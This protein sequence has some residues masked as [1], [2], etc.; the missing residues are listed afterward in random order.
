MSKGFCL[1][2]SRIIAVRASVNY[3]VDLTDE[4]FHVGDTTVHY[5][6]V[7]NIESCTTTYTGFRRKLPSGEFGPDGFWDVLP[8][9]DDAM[10][11]EGEVFGGNPFPY[12]PY[13]WSETYP[14]VKPNY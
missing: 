7:C 10:G 2:C 8:W 14:N 5:R 11:P 3:R 13:E 6:T 9:S 4:A 12:L 1:I